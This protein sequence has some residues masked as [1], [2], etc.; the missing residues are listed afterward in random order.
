MEM[1]VNTI[2]KL[3]F[4]YELEC[5]VCFHY[6]YDNSSLILCGNIN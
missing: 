3:L 1:A 6:S 4:L 2:A 5:E